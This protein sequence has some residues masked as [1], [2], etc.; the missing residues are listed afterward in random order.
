[1]SLFLF[2]REF[3]VEDPGHYGQH[4][5]TAFILCQYLLFVRQTLAP[6]SDLAQYLKTSHSDRKAQV[7]VARVEMRRRRHSGGGGSGGDGNGDNDRLQIGR[8]VWG[9]PPVSSRE[10]RAGLILSE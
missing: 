7:K 2:K 4:A 6:H 9:P 3:P 8:R 1:M 5:F 10:A